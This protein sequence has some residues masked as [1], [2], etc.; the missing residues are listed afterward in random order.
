VGIPPAVSSVLPP[1][2]CICPLTAFSTASFT[3]SPSPSLPLPSR[4]RNRHLE[5]Q[6]SILQLLH[7]HVMATSERDYFV[8]VSGRHLK[9]TLWDTACALVAQHSTIGMDQVR[10]RLPCALPS[11]LGAVP[12]MLLPPPTCITPRCRANPSEESAWENQL[13]GEPPVS[14]AC[15]R[16]GFPTPMSNP[17]RRYQSYTWEGF[18]AYY[19]VSREYRLAPGVAHHCLAGRVSPHLAPTSPSEPPS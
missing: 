16:Q 5:P 4:F 13:P 3:I 10:A 15:T 2:L 9:R 19:A 14:P 17:R 11:V 12:C 8:E 18:S 7:H 1:T 6:G